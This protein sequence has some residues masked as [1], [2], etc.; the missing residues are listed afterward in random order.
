MDGSDS[1]DGDLLPP[2]RAYFLQFTSSVFGRVHN[3]IARRHVL[4]VV[5]ASDPVHPERPFRLS[6]TVLPVSRGARFPPSKV[7]TNSLLY[8]NREVIERF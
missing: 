8:A 6:F 7:R 3:G 1:S 4:A 2:D 5:L